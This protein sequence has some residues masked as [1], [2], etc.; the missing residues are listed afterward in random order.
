MLKVTR[1]MVATAAALVI[2]A[3][4]AAAEEDKVSQPAQTAVKAPKQKQPD[5]TGDMAKI[6]ERTASETRETGTYK[7][8]TAAEKQA[9]KED[10][11]KKRTGATPEEQQKQKTQSPG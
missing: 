5:A 7:K 2:P 3:V 6:Q 11:K 4:A 9:A 10:K 8:K 1:L